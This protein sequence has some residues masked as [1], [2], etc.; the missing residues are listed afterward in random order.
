MLI[1]LFKNRLH[2]SHDPF[3]NTEHCPKKED[4]SQNQNRYKKGFVLIVK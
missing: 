2:D 1:F 4:E 3:K